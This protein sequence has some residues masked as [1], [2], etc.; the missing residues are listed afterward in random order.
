NFHI[1]LNLEQ[2][3]PYNKAYLCCIPATRVSPNLLFFVYLLQFTPV[4]AIQTAGQKT[5]KITKVRIEN[6]ATFPLPKDTEQTI[7]K[8]LDFLPME[9]LRGL[10][11]IKLVDFIND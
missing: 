1:S 7:N 9:H 4:M 6:Q 2:T 3:N 10:E 8:A 11:K 5:A